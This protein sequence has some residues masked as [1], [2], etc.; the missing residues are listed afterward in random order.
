MPWYKVI[1]FGIY[2][3]FIFLHICN[4]WQIGSYAIYHHDMYPASYGSAAIPLSGIPDP[5]FTSFTNR[6]LSFYFKPAGSRKNKILD[7]NFFGFVRE[8]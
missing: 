2:Q 8:I 5:E 7:Y 3:N 6:Y 1:L 4:V